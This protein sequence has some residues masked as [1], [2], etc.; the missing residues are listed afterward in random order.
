MGSPPGT[1]SVTRKKKKRKQA[2]LL[3]DLACA[4]NACEKAGLD[5]KLKC[6]IVWTDVGFVLPVKDRWVS[7]T[8]RQLTKL[9]LALKDLVLYNRSMA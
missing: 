4:I 8:L 6:G 9:A 1:S 3:H 7:R 5:V 2:L